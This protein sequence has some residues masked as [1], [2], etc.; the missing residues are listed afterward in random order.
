[1]EF[2]GQQKSERHEKR[3]SLEHEDE[4]KIKLH[5]RDKRKYIGLN[6]FVVPA[7]E[8]SFLAPKN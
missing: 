3:F 2:A 1:M 4:K 8:Y 5:I 6:V 7:N